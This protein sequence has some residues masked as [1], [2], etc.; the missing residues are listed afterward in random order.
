MVGGSLVGVT[1]TGGVLPFGAKVGVVG[2]R[3]SMVAVTELS[4]GAIL[5]VVPGTM[6]E[7]WRLHFE[8]FGGT[9]APRRG[10][11]YMHVCLTQSNF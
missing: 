1:T 6:N 3:T 9:S 5:P 2:S 8:T 10:V 7:E 4:G 11:C